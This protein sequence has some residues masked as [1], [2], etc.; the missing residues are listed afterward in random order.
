MNNAWSQ[1]IRVYNEG[2]ANFINIQLQVNTSSLD[3]G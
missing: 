1:I 3:V 2:G